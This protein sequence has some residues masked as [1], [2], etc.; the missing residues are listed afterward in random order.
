MLVENVAIFVNG[1]SER[2]K[3]YIERVVIMDDGSSVDPSS[4]E[5]RLHPGT[6]LALQLLKGLKRLKH[7][8]WDW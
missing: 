2:K 8:K 6:D 1:L 7:V 5:L 4:G 3:D